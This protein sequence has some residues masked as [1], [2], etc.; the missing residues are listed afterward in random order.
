MKKCN[1][2][3]GKEESLNKFENQIIH[4][5]LFE[6]MPRIPD[7]SIDMVFVDPPYNL[8]KEYNNYQDNKRD[9]EYIEWCNRWLSECIRVLK[10]TGSLFVINIPKWLIY[11]AYYLNKIAVFNHWIAWDAMGSPTNSKLMPNHYGILWYSKT[12]KPKYYSIRIPHPR[13]RKKELLA[14]WGGK[15]SMLHPYGK[16]AGDIWNDI[17]RIR[18]R[19]RRDMHPCQLPVHLIERLIL[20]TTDEGDI[21][22]DPMVGTGTTAVAAKRM[23]RRFIGIDIDKNYVEIAQKNVEATKPIKINGVYVSI[24]LGKVVTIR[25]LDYEKIEPFLKIKELKI[26]GEKTKQMRLPEIDK[27]K[28]KRYASIQEF[29]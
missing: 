10:P 25:D 4:G 11:H 27:R 21:I 19:V 16:I 8:K 14:D 2:F 3:M 17:H 9:N 13:D 23:G 6:I 29:F 26:N 5:D 22:L 20:A 28:L 24:Y 1:I 7:N 18:H 15:K 12:N